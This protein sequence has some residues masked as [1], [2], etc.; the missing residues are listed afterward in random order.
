MCNVFACC[1][2]DELLKLARGAL[3]FGI[4]LLRGWLLSAAEAE[5]SRSSKV[6]TRGGPGL[7]A[8]VLSPSSV[9]DFWSPRD[10][11]KTSDHKGHPGWKLA[12]GKSKE[13]PTLNQKML[14]ES[15]NTRAG[16]QPVQS[17]AHADSWNTS[18]DLC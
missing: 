8:W 7:L 12:L 3:R 11:L 14:K 4:S 5:F 15:N 16:S 18:V 2:L 17:Q 6:V 9:S 13:S 1:L 10:V